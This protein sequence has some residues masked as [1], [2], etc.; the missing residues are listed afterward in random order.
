[1]WIKEP[2]YNII[3]G[4]ASPRRVELLKGLDLP[5]QQKVIENI[6]E[7]YPDNISITSV[8][9][10]LSCL[11]SKAYKNILSDNDLLIT[12]DTVVIIDDC[13]LGKPKDKREA[14]KML[15]KLSGRIH[16]VVSGV[17][18]YF[19]N[20]QISFS[21]TTMVEFNCI[22]DDEIMYYIDNYK[23]YDKAGSYGIQD[24]IGLRAIRSI[25]GSFY[26][27]MGLP[28]DKLS[29]YLNDILHIK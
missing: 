11:K 7:V 8:P 26:N 27:V 28:I 1:M 12:C 15:H 20:K 10:Y 13:L 22:S 16:K 6:K 29:S 25:K 18:L 14:K 19:E 3:L 23:P 24:W 2:K 5:F 21:D 4:S 9:E 17:C